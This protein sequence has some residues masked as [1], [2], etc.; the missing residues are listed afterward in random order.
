MPSKPRPR[1]LQ[2]VISQRELATI[3]YALRRY[4]QMGTL[5]DADHFEE[6]TPLSVQ[7]TNSLCQRLTFSPYAPKLAA[8]NVPLTPSDITTIEQLSGFVSEEV[9]DQMDRTTKRSLKRLLDKLRIPYAK[10]E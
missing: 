7:E 10:T 9:G 5:V 2:P 4:Q 3:L 6:Y 1:N 8:N